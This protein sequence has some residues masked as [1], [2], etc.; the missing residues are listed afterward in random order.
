MEPIQQIS[1]HFLIE[2]FPLSVPH[3][4]FPSLAIFCFFFRQPF[5]PHS[6]SYILIQDLTLSGALLD[7]ISIPGVVSGVLIFAQHVHTI[8]VVFHLPCILLCFFLF[9]A[10]LYNFLFS[11]MKRQFMEEF[12]LSRY[13]F[14]TLR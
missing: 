4:S 11:I 13:T 2:F 1:L 6:F 14:K 9:P 5:L 7:S 10:Y 3:S 12:N 8:S